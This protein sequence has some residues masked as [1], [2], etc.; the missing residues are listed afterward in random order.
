MEHES[1][2][3][4]A[5][6]CDTLGITSRTLRFYEEKGIIHSTTVGTSSRRHYTDKQLSVIKNVLVLRT[7]GL[8]I[9]DIAELQNQEADLKN[10]ILSHRA[11]IYASIDTRLREINLLNEALCALESGRNIFTEKWQSFSDAAPEETETA[12]S[13][14]DAILRGDD[15][16]LYMYFSP[17]LAQY[18]PRDVYSTIRK[19]T[20]S[21]LGE[22]MSIDKIAADRDSPNKIF[23]FVRFSKMGLKITF[24]FYSGQIH[25]LWLGYYDT[26]AR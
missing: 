7:L 18:M 6:V 14:T 12:R 21:P 15:D 11:E 10:T 4:I 5:E 13:C 25:G 24:V 19:D 8:S 22:F 17:R 1:L 16:F 9:K 2:H 3:D 23:S 20:L 26:N